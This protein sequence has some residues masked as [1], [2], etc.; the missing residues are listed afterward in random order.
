LL[1]S[2]VKIG[3]TEIFATSIRVIGNGCRR[4]RL[5]KVIHFKN[6][7]GR[8]LLGVPYLIEH[9]LSMGNS[10]LNRKLMRNGKDGKIAAGLL[11]RSFGEFR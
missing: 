4:Q 7:S 3:T 6:P 9:G 10:R 1:N 8:R 2:K 11:N 5:A